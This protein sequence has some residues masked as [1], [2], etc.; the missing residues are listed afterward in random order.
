M[1]NRIEWLRKR[2]EEQ[3]PREHDYFCSYVIGVLETEMQYTP[4][5]TYTV[6]EV[7]EMLQMINNARFRY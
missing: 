4:D 5:N 3:K 2:L 6:A 7:I 1:E